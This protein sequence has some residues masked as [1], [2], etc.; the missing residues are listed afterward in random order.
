MTNPGG[1][2]SKAAGG[3]VRCGGRKGNSQRG[4]SLSGL[5]FWCVLLGT[6]ALIG[7]KLFPLYNEKMKVDF[8]LDR[9]AGDPA[10]GTQTKQDL[11]KGVM[12][13]FEISDVDRWTTPEFARLLQVQKDPETDGRIMSLDY[14]IRGPLCCN[15]DVVLNYHKAVPLAGAAE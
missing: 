13:Q 9:V 12:K 5:L 6:L 14:E 2:M 11:V 8:A 15:L 7:M 10:A 1:R 4:L 3:R